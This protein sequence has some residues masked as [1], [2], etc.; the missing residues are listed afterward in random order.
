MILEICF[1][2]GTLEACDIVE[3]INGMRIKN[4]GFKLFI[5]HQ[6]LYHRYHH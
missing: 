1:V 2:N 4:N 5:I 6:L 3:V